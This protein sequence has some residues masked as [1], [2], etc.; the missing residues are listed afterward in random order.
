MSNTQYQQNGVTDL[1]ETF[2]GPSLQQSLPQIAQPRGD[3][4]QRAPRSE[5]VAALAQKLP[6]EQRANPTI[7]KDHPH[8]IHMEKYFSSLLK[9][10]R[11]SILEILERTFEPHEIY[12]FEPAT[13]PSPVV[14]L[15]RANIIRYKRILETRFQGHAP[16]LELKLAFLYFGLP[17]A[18]MK[19]G[20][21]EMDLPKDF[22]FGEDNLIVTSDP[23]QFLDDYSER[24]HGDSSRRVTDPHFPQIHTTQEFPSMRLRG[25]ALPADMQW[26][27]EDNQN[28]SQP[29]NSDEMRVYG[30]QGS[31]LAN[32]KKPLYDSFVEAVDKVLGVTHGINYN[33]CLQ[34]WNV[35]NSEAAN[36]VGQATGMVRH[37]G[38]QS[39]ETDPLFTLLQQWFTDSSLDNQYCCFVYFDK[40][41]SPNFYQPPY[42][43]ERYIVRVWDDDNNNMAYMKVPP[44]LQQTHKPNQFHAEY[45]RAIRM[46]FPEAP[47]GYLQFA[48]GTKRFTYGLFDPP[49]K[50]WTKIIGEQATNGELPLL[51]FNLI[52]IP[53]D[54]VAVSVPGF[55]AYNTDFSPSELS[56]GKQ[57]GVFHKDDIKLTGTNQDRLGLERIL[58][59]VSASNRSATSSDEFAGVD[60]W[61]PGEGY[62]NIRGSS[63]R[64]ALDNKE[65][66]IQSLLDW[67][68]VVGGFMG[69]RVH[70]PNKSLSVVA[71]PVFHT[72]RFH[73]DD[74]TDRQFSMR[75][76]DG[77]ES[78]SEFK[79]AIRSNFFPKFS[80][81]KK[82]PVLHLT[83]TTWA[84]NK[85]DFVIGFDTDEEG[86]SW[87]VRRITEPDI[88][89]SLENWSSDWSVE[90]KTTW[91]PRYNSTY[92]STVSS[93]TESTWRPEPF[94]DTMNHIFRKSGNNRDGATRAQKLRERLFWDIPSV[95]TNPAKPAI[96]IHAA[97][98][99]TIIRT[100]R[101]VPAFTTAMRTPGEM[102][103][104]EREVHTLRGNLLD[105]IKECPYM[106][107]E[108]YFAF[109]DSKGLDR[110]LREDHNTLRCFLCETETTLLPYYNNDAIRRHYINVHSDDIKDTMTDP[111]SSGSNCEGDPYCNRC[112]R[113]RKLLNNPD[114]QTSHDQD[115]TLGPTSDETYCIHC[116]SSRE[117]PDYNNCD[118][119]QQ[120][121]DARDPGDYCDKCG[122]R[123]DPSWNRI[124]R[125]RHNKECRRPGGELN[126]Y[127]PSCGIILADKSRNDRLRHIISCKRPGPDNV[128]ARSGPVGS[129][130]PVV[131]KPTNPKPVDPKPVNPKP[132]FSTGNGNDKGEP[133]NNPP[134]PTG[135]RSE[136]ETQDTDMPPADYTIQD[137]PLGW[138]EAG[139]SDPIPHR[140]SRSPVW[141]FLLEQPAAGALSF[142][143]DSDWKCSR[144]FRAAGYN[145]DQ[146]EMHMSEDGSCKIRRGLGTTKVSSL[147]N[148]SG[149]IIPSEKFDFGTAFFR[150]VDRYPAYRSTMFPVREQSVKRTWEKPYDL[151][152]A[153]GSLRDD[154][155]IPANYKRT[156]VLELPWP[157]YEG[158]VIPLNVPQSPAPT[159]PDIPSWKLGELLNESL[160]KPPNEPS[161][162]PSD[163]S[164]DEPLGEPSNEQLDELVDEI[165]GELPDGP[166]VEPSDEPRDPE[167][168]TGPETTEDPTSNGDDDQNINPE[169]DGEPPIDDATP[170]DD[171]NPFVLPPESEEDETFESIEETPSSDT[172]SSLQ[173]TPVETD[174]AGKEN[175]PRKRKRT[176]DRDP[177]FSQL[178]AA[179]ED[180]EEE[181]SEAGAVPDP[182]QNLDPDAPR[183]PKKPKKPKKAKKA[184]ARATD[185]PGRPYISLPPDWD[186]VA[187]IVRE[188]GRGSRP[189]R[190]TDPSPPGSHRSASP[191]GGIRRSTVPRRSGRVRKSNRRYTLPV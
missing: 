149:W 92:I 153:I 167:G 117:D 144:C 29:P 183:T 118:C 6:F 89:V 106:D 165:L 181:Y 185:E 41:S 158:T 78:F 75:V 140:R 115:C 62:L 49:P 111:K 173:L 178:P 146:A 23:L 84:K 58:A 53:D 159:P 2:L 12:L 154:P 182:V 74:S 163:E 24:T 127:C 79:A 3:L 177:T 108:R 44:N 131:P 142:Q 38:L 59:M 63:S 95:F 133:S 97:P 132:T 139:D 161:D 32:Q 122:M 13:A 180:V 67:R 134:D 155:N 130:P 184:K 77:E 143:P 107:C 157:P 191:D 186:Q 104:L 37:N 64:V 36:V 28:T 83:Q 22:D 80:D 73:A 141:T 151:G 113:N 174:D 188:S 42:E 99:E 27:A 94:D 162:E 148:R 135:G 150:F 30:Y 160:D 136:P 46:L 33:I 45:M 20:I 43:L 52:H 50:V 31:V 112:G 168:D 152:N 16:S 48:T 87:I 69:P 176:G 5:D 121:K 47:H 93:H 70:N 7:H 8:F 123:Y 66:S 102:A 120:A 82:G 171:N 187:K 56:S 68:R 71:R 164:S 60:L 189:P 18:P 170:A 90:E 147:P 57:V 100:G 137:P 172:D 9:N 72:Y 124:Y 109:K 169:K 166:P 1:T 105:R 125:E 54:Y 14:D 81:T 88:T 10:T 98:V 26:E 145:P 15:Q 85:V 35:S 21:P 175:S 86:W 190:T 96:P 19:P 103:R 101:Y 39:P 55:H 51:S 138:R 25:G 4:F 65:I 116:G 76:I 110:H 129:K 128:A 61:I 11:L 114:D 40:E 156:R 119:G 91:G 126:D 34:I 179:D 17:V